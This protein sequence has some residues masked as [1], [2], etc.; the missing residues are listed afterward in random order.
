M[1]KKT[2]LISSLVVLL[3]SGCNME[4][5][6]PDIEIKNSIEQITGNDTT[7]IKQVI[8]EIEST[9]EEI[10]NTVVDANQEHEDVVGDSFYEVQR[11]VDGI[12]SYY[13]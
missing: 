9:I 13:S 5:T 10:S 2:I 4:T 1:M 12:Y 11:I 6:V 7:D 3:L 8:K